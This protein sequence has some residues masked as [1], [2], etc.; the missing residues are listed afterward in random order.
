[1]VPG[2]SSHAVMPLPGVAISA[3][4]LSSSALVAAERCAPPWQVFRPAP[5]PSDE[6]R[7]RMPR[8]ELDAM[9]AILP[10][11]LAGLVVVVLTIVAIVS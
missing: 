9:T 7:Q 4:T 10:A 2:P 1:M 11:F 5:T 3:A 6:D 8:R